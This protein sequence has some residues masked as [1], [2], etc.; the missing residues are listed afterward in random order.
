VFVGCGATA[1]FFSDLLAPS[2]AAAD[3]RRAASLG[4]D[5]T[6]CAHVGSRTVAPD[7]TPERFRRLRDALER[8]QPDL[9]VL[10][11]RVHKSH[12]FSAI[13]RSCDAVGVLEAHVVATDGAVAV[14]HATSAGTKKWV[15]IRGHASIADA[16]AH[17]REKGFGIVAAHPSS[18]AIDYRE[19]DY[20]RP[21][22]I[23]LGAELH[24]VSSEALELADTLVTIPMAGLVQSLN[25]SVASALLLFEAHRQRAAAG[26]YA[27][28]RLPRAD[29]DARLFEWAHPALARRRREAGRAYPPLGPEG[30]VLPD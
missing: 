20:T 12:N 21:V 1:P 19:V 4:D 13:L 9:T 14:H 22:A 29:F 2:S 28:S 15:A 7:M 16:A 24:G 23:T 27:H 25:V 18:A 10:M 5:R 30:E 17:L 26:M 11:D 6:L 3:S 8:R